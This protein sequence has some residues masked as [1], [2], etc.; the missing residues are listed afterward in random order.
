VK[1]VKPVEK[2]QENV[3]GETKLCIEYK[4]TENFSKW[5]SQVI[6]KSEMIDYYEISGCYILRPW[7]FGIWEIIQKFFDDLI[8]TVNKKY[9]AINILL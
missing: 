1:E 4:K 3:K 7:A 6:T 9:Y 2:K 8:K 5:Y